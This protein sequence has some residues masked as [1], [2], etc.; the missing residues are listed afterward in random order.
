MIYC[1]CEDEDKYCGSPAAASWGMVK[2]QRQ[3]SAGITLRS[4]KLNGMPSRRDA[5][6]GVKVYGFD[7]TRKVT[8]FWQ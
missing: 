2:A 1:K 5:I 8:A 3:G 4:S 6:Y 7:R